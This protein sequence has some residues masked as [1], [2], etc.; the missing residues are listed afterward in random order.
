MLEASF[1]GLLRTV[2]IIIGV[3]AVLRFLG[4]FF[5]AKREQ[6]RIRNLE[7]NQKEVKKAQENA[8]RTEGQIS[9]SDAKNG[10]TEGETE[11][12]DFEET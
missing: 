1:T 8:R 10:K 11:D 4:R 2:F 9:I 5:A 6:E 7:I 3:I 12:V